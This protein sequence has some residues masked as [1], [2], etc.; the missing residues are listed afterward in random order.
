MIL[1]IVKLISQY[2][3]LVSMEYIRIINIFTSKGVKNG[4][5]VIFVTTLIFGIFLST[6]WSLVVQEEINSIQEGHFEISLLSPNSWRTGTWGAVMA[7]ELPKIGIGIKTHSSTG[8]DVIGPRTFSHERDDS[9]AHVDGNGNTVGAIPTYDE[10]G[11]DIF[12]VGLSGAIDYN[13]TSSY[14]NVQFSPSSNNFASYDNDE[15]STLIT[16]YTSEYEPAERA[17]IAPL[18]QQY[19]YDDQPYINIINTAG[20]WTYDAAWTKLTANDLLF[21]GTTNAGDRWKDIEHDTKTDIVYVHSYEL[22]EFTPFAIQSYIAAQYLNPIYPGLYERD[23]N[24]PNLAYKPVIANA[25]P[26][27]NTEKTVATIEINPAARFSTGETVTVEDVANSFHM[28]M[29]P[30]WSVAYYSDLTTYL[31]NRDAIKV[32]IDGKLEITLEEPYFL[33]N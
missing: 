3:R 22:T 25:L 23:I 1:K 20:L 16:K 21:F 29:S 10:D 4:I 11:F 30:E 24:D 18:I 5:T 17:K 15:I 33:A 12:F 9:S 13:P 19:M 31:T 27:W 14:S 32:T 6:A 8:W 2:T 7:E 26:E 28:H